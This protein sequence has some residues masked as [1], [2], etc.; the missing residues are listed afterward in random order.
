MSKSR[1]ELAHEMKLML[2][3]AMV[4]QANARELGDYTESKRQH[5]ALCEAIDAL[6]AEPPQ[7]VGLAVRWE[8]LCKESGVWCDIGKEA[9]A[10]MRED[11]YELRA[12]GVIEPAQGWV[13]VEDRVPTLVDDNDVAVYTW[14][15]KAVDEDTYGPVFEQPAGPMVGGWLRVGENFGDIHRNVTHWMPRELPAPPATNHP[16]DTK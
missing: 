15:G 14:D 10:W 8:F 5:T 3:A 9:P 1:M 2:S 7:A 13:G 4:A 12:L 11:G 6:A 16:K